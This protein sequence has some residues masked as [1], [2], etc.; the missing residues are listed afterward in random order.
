[1]AVS[2]ESK[3]VAEP[4]AAAVLVHAPRT[5]QE[6][7]D[8]A[9]AIFLSLAMLGLCGL[10][11]AVLYK[12]YTTDLWISI[13]KD[14]YL[15]VVGVPASIITAIA[16]VQFFRGLHGPIE[17]SVAGAKFSGATGPVILW[18]F[19]YLAVIWGM[20]YLWGT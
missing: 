7:I 13:F 6:M 15:A 17:F 10:F 11:L 8:I 1:M 2:R 20:K 16:L 9:S 4:I 18:I 12:G 19:S 5:A 3:S 14:H